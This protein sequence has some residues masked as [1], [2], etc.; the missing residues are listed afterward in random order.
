MRLWWWS[1]GGVD[2]DEKTITSVLLE[3]VKSLPVPL[4]ALVLFFW[5]FLISLP[6]PPSIAQS[7]TM[8]QACTIAVRTVQ[9]AHIRVESQTKPVCR[10]EPEQC[11]CPVGS[12][13]LGVP[14]LWWNVWTEQVFLPIYFCFA[15]IER[16]VSTSWF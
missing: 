15:L 10:A 7:A 6:S 2:L 5:F 12:V 3:E 9:S 13:V 4:D 1:K 16:T 11:L 8:P 14:S